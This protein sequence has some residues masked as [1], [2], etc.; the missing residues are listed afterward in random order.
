MHLKLSFNLHAREV[1]E[2]SVNEQILEIAVTGEKSN[3]LI[4]PDYETLMNSHPKFGKIFVNQVLI[5]R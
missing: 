2:R 4:G 1:V 5:G 3:L